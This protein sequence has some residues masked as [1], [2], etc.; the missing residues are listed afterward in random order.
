MT[1]KANT[2]NVDTTLKAIHDGAVSLCNAAITAELKTKETWQAE[3]AALVKQC[4]TKAEANHAIAAMQEHQAKLEKANKWVSQSTLAKKYTVLKKPFM[5]I[6]GRWRDGEEV[7]AAK[8]AGIVNRYG[9]HRCYAKLNEAYPSGKGR[10]AAAPAEPTDRKDADKGAAGSAANKVETSTTQPAADEAAIRE[11]VQE[12]MTK[13]ATE[14]AKVVAKASP[15]AAYNA[16]VS[17]LQVLKQSDSEELSGVGDAL[18]AA[19]ELYHAERAKREAGETPKATTKTKVSKLRR[20]VG[21]CA[22]SGDLV[23]KAMA[24]AMDAAVNA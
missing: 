17:A 21:K 24:K 15:T 18:G 12:V 20:A 8:V 10:K 13:S 16:L 7:S 23:G 14:L 19:L 5:V 9:W 11:Q 6:A 4:G 2:P 22:E 3:L 1:T